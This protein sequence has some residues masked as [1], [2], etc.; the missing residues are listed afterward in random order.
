MR[1]R[2]GP[3][4]RLQRQSLIAAAQRADRIASVIDL[5]PRLGGGQC[6]GQPA[7]SRQPQHITQRP[8]RPRQAEIVIKRR[9]AWRNGPVLSKIHCPRNL[10]HRSVGREIRCDR[11]IMIGR[12]PQPMPGPGWTAV[13]IPIAMMGDVQRC[14]RIRLRLDRQEERIVG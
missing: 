5:H 10:G 13:K 7:S 9:I 11:Q 6:Q 3:E 12:H 14:Q 4:L 2:I 1:Q 8:A